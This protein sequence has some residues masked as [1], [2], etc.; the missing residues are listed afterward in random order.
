M[1]SQTLHQGCLVDVCKWKWECTVLGLI[2]FL[3]CNSLRFTEFLVEE[4][5][6]IEDLRQLILSYFPGI[7]LPN[8]LTD[9]TIR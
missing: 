7:D 3:A 6:S 8:A 5:K 2:Q 1:G 9:G 4:M